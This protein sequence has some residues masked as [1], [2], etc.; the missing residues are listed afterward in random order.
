MQTLEHH[1]QKSSIELISPSFS[2][3][4]RIY[5]GIRVIHFLP[6]TTSLYFNLTITRSF[7]VF[8]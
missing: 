2:V 4:K 3:G 5:C 1:S 8:L 7:S 6:E